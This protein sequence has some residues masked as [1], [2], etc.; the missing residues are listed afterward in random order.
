MAD[1]T[2]LRIQHRLATM[3]NELSNPWTDPMYF[4]EDVSD[5][6]VFFLEDY[7]F[8]SPIFWFLY[9][10]F[11]VY[12]ALK[13]ALYLRRDYLRFLS[14]GRGGRPSTVR[15]WLQNKLYKF[16]LMDIIGV[17]I[18]STPFV[19]PLLE[20]YNGGLYTFA[21]PQRLGD[22]PEIIGVGP[23]RQ[24]TDAIPG[25]ERWIR[26]LFVEVG[27]TDPE[28]FRYQTS[29][30]TGLPAL[31][32]NLP[33]APPNGTPGAVTEWGGEIA[34][35]RPDGSTMICLHPSD[36]DELI[37]LGWG[38]RNPLAVM[39][40]TWLWKF[41]HHRILRTRTP[42]PHNMVIVYA[43]RDEVEQN[44]FNCIL[45]CALWWAHSQRS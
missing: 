43:P 37:E 16:L 33:E 25:A 36:A 17:D 35:V 44:V 24:R 10:I 23:M 40:E 4:Y 11:I 22:R 45:A 2:L 6:V 26:N 13:T 42:L 32:R 20:P 29:Y 7:C 39:N 31:T 27:L 8:C 28:V 34:H 9:Y 5:A 3:L 12:Y 38:Q 18:L 19:D 21:I 1:P 30:L 15:G 41:F 14:L